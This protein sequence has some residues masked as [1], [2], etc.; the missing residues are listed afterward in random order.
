MSLIT[1][2]ELVQLK[3]YVGIDTSEMKKGT[4]SYFLA[5]DKSARGIYQIWMG[6][7]TIF[8]RG[9]TEQEFREIHLRQYN[10]HITLLNSLYTYLQKNSKGLA[11]EQK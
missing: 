4:G 1:V 2:E 9:N 6:D 11:S 3:W 7:A 10:D 8:Y 5:I